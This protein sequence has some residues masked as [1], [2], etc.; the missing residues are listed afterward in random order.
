MGRLKEDLRTKRKDH[1]LLA[2]DHQFRGRAP[3][4]RNRMSLIDIL[5]AYIIQFNWKNSLPAMKVD[6]LDKR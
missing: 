4:V 3:I 6:C 5:K 1:L 2:R